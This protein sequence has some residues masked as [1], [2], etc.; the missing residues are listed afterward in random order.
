MPI[1][2]HVRVDTVAYTKSKGSGFFRSD[3]VAKGHEVDINS[4]LLHS[5]S[6]NLIELLFIAQW[7][8][9]LF[10]QI[11]KD[12][13]LSEKFSMERSRKIKQAKGAALFVAG[14]EIEVGRI[15]C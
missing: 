5:P 8:L 1:Q 6:I 13:L 10:E 9:F 12:L 11:V 4:R 15:D 2:L 14:F 3:G 7:C